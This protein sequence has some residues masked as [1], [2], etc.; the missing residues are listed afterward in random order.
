MLLVSLAWKSSSITSTLADLCTESQVSA[1]SR[2][3]PVITL[4]GSLLAAAYTTYIL[5]S[6][7]ANQLERYAEVTWSMDCILPFTF[8]YTLCYA[9]ATSSIYCL[10][11]HVHLQ[12]SVHTNEC[13]RKVVSGTMSVNEVQLMFLNVQE[14]RRAI[15]QSLG[16]LP[17]TLC[18]QLFL[19]ITVLKA[20]SMIFEKHAVLV[21]LTSIVNL[22]ASVMIMVFIIINLVVECATSQA[23]R[24]RNQVILCLSN[25][26]GAHFEKSVAGLLELTQD[27]VVP[28]LAWGVF[29][30]GKE[31]IFRFFGALIPF[32]VMVVPMLNDT[33]SKWFGFKLAKSL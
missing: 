19:Q 7:E 30:I 3:L 1:G 5:A 27:P 10:Y 32:V 31:F 6:F 18:V 23:D 12:L 16:L 4:G 22:E 24:L 26:G 17:F 15:N 33:E 2:V 9:F 28:S 14:R 29:P 11:V 8:V 13:H 20:N 21:Q 25:A